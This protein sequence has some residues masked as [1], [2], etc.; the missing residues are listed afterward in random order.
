[1]DFSNTQLF[2][3]SFNLFSA[4]TLIEQFIYVLNLFTPYRRDGE[5]VFYE[6][7]IDLAHLNA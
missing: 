7:L 1:M 2:Q 5:H 4:R 6:F 3:F